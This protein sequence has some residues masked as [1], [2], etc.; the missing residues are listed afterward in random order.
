MTDFWRLWHRWYAPP[1]PGSPIEG[2]HGCT[3]R[4]PE[5]SSRHRVADQARAVASSI[6]V[7][8]TQLPPLPLRL[9]FCHVSMVSTQLP[10]LPLWLL[11]R[12][13]DGE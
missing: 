11:L 1:V 13:V 12:H 7:T 10:P 4:T 8:S 6:R 9:L 3:G 5:W 2:G